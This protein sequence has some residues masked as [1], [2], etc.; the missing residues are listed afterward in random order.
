MD[1]AAVEQLVESF[2]SKSVP[3]ECR[4]LWTPELRG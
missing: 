1:R 3:L 4:N 2:A